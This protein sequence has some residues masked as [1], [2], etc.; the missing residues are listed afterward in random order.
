M[1]DNADTPQY[2]VLNKVPL[3]ES[4]NWQVFNRR[5]REYLILAGYDD[6]LETNNG[7]PEPEEGESDTS[8]GKRSRQRKSRMMRACTV[9]RSR[10][11]TNAY[12]NVEN[13]M[14]LNVLLKT[15]EEKCKNQGT[16]SL[17]ELVLEFWTLR[18]EDYKSV[19][20]YAEKFRDINKDLKAISI[21]AERSDLFGH[22]SQ[23]H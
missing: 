9:I 22:G 13:E 21:I 6:L 5:A 23:I 1:T 20:E 16:G 17:I 2:S 4:H 15:L 11:G 14:L 19:T 8:F 18:L 7:V 10:C 3:L 12:A